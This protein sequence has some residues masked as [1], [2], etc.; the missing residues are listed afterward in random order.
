M[1]LAVRLPDTP[2]IQALA[3]LLA[4]VAVI[5]ASAIFLSLVGQDRRHFLDRC[6]SDL[7]AT[8]FLSA[9][10]DYIWEGA[11]GIFDNHDDKVVGP[12]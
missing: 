12:K 9:T 4:V 11:R 7:A 8:G 5:I 1:N 3:I 6:N 10:L 2:V